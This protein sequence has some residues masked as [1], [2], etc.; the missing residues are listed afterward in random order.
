MRLFM[1]EKQKRRREANFL[2][3]GSILA[4][5]SVI[6]R[7]IGIVYRI[8]LTNILGD[9]GNAAYTNA[10]EIYSL[11]WM[12][13]SFGIPTAVSK[14]VAE[15]IGNKQEWNASRVF[16]TALLFAT[17]V[18]AA[19]Y[20]VLFFGAGF[21][22]DVVYKRAEIKYALMVLAPTVWI[23]AFMGAFRGFF[24]GYGTMVPTAISQII[25]QIVNAVMSILG[26]WIL[27][28]MG[29]RLDLLHGDDL[30]ADAL[31]AAGGTVGTLSGAAAGLIVCIVI[32]RMYYAGSSEKISGESKVKESYKQLLSTL[33]LMI[34]PITL[35]SAIYNISSV[36]DSAIFSNFADL[37]GMSG[38][39]YQ[40]SWNAYSGK[41]HL[42]THVP[43]AFATALSAS[44]VPNLSRT[45]KTSTPAQITQ[46]IRTAIRFAMLIAIP[47][48]VGLAVLSRPILQ[49][50]FAGTPESNDL[51]SRLLIMGG[52]TVI[53]YSFSTITNGVLQGIGRVKE[54]A[55]NAA[56]SLAAHL[57]ILILCLWLLPFG[58]YGVVAADIIFGL[59]MNVMN[60]RSIYRAIRFKLE[61]KCTFLLPAVSS[62]LMGI[63]AWGTWKGLYILL[64][65]NTV[66]VL[67]A[68]CVAVA[69]YAVALLLTGA[70][71][72][73]DLKAFPKGALLVKIAKKL[74]LLRKTA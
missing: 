42:L 51:A 54:P 19:A 49:L 7:L 17:V 5:A 55:K 38:N 24:Q 9:G 70:I 27:W 50:L 22:A 53:L 62:V 10:Y 23:S 56:V 32:Y 33:V 68:I 13:A 37:S 35:N 71:S 8:P 4:I 65:S 3:Q 25:E 64:K 14:M 48:C 6:V 29:H 26:A 20:S 72:E 73:S 15:R 31:G 36:L 39:A 74:H 46:K 44:A 43:L 41:Y 57:V 63:A 28:N 21:F 34:L 52:I 11:I 12:I 2:I 1:A 45:L 58:I 61:I 47:S 67:L 60:Y 69:V 40:I 16:V 30:W 18:G 59:M 66:A